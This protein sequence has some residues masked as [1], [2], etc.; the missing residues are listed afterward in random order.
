[1]AIFK[2][3]EER[4]IERS[5]A[6]RK[7]LG[8]FAGQIKKLAKQEAGYIASA[9]DA[10]RVGAA[11]QAAL[12]KKALKATMLQRRRLEHQVLTLKIASQMKDQAE[13]H[14][15]FAKALSAVSKTIGD[16]FA[17]V[18]M[19]ATQ[20]KFEI[21]MGKAESMEQRVDLFLETS[22]ETVFGES[23]DSGELVSDAEIDKLIDIEAAD[24]EI[25]F[26]DGVETKLKEVQ[27]ALARE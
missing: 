7:T 4:R 3:K 17:A 14:G 10:C 12:A 8:M 21:A 11:S 5:I 2:S 19:T 18:D 27:D 16:M 1:M 26:D 15:M 24:S 22:N 13:M 25:G 9:K 6:V 20:K 23:A